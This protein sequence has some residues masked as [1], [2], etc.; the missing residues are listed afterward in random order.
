[1]ANSTISKAW[2]LGCVDEIT[3]DNC[4]TPKIQGPVR[5]VQSGPGVGGP[6]NLNTPRHGD[7][8]RYIGRCSGIG[9]MRSDILRRKLPT[10]TRSVSCTTMAEKSFGKANSTNFGTAHMDLWLQPESPSQ[11]NYV[12]TSQVNLSQELLMH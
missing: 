4:G 7:G 8:R 11:L 5:R 6:E 3:R 9:L 10:A 1:M 2:S 12:S